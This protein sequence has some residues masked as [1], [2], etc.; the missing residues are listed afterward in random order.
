MLLNISQISLERI[1][2][3]KVAKIWAS[4]VPNYPPAPEEK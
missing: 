1:M 3:Y 2:I 4:V